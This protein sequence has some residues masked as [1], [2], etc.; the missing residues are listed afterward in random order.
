MGKPKD[1]FARLQDLREN[2]E[3]L[4]LRLNLG[5]CRLWGPGIQAEGQVTPVYPEGLARSHPGRE[6]P[7][8]PFGKGCGI[9]AL[10]VPID[11]PKGAPGRDPLVAPECLRKWGDAVEQTCLILERLRAYPEG[12]VRKDLLRYCLDACRVVHL[13]RSTELEEAGQSPAMLR[14]K[15]Q[16]VV[17][18]LLGT[19]ISEDAWE[20]VCLPI[21]LGGLGISDPFVL[22][23]AARLAALVNLGLN[24]AK[25]VGVPANV[26]AHP[27]PDLHATLGRL[28]AQLGPNMEPLARWVTEPNP[29]ASATSQH[30]TQKWWAEQVD[31]VR[32]QMVDGKGSVRDRVRRASQ[33]GPVATAWLGALP[34]RAAR[35]EIPDAEFRLL[36]RWW[37]GLPILPTG[38]TLPECPLCRES[39][40]PFGDHLVCCEQNGCA[41]RHNAFRN[42]FFAV[43][44]QHGIA[45]EK[46]PECLAGRRPADVLLLLWTRGQHV[47]VDFVCTHP[48][49]PAQYPLEGARG[50]KH[51]NRA[52]AS[53]LRE[54]SAP[55]Q[56]KGWGFSP[57]AVST[58]GGLGTSAKAVL[59]EVSKRATADLRG[60]PKTHALQAIR[61][62]LSVTLMREVAR[63]LTVKGRVQDAVCP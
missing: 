53:K 31:E 42:A 62:T 41:A 5:K 33:K 26:L 54:N 18:D 43:C 46:E 3:P 40:D 36:L 15:L 28:Q 34:S 57:F 37:L 1:V 35:T 23:P 13:L 14:A 50:A 16:E 7:V 51:C 21:R 39:V 20:Q 11:A 38:V 59:F 27:A 44:V 56:E 29:L 2:L 19:G 17:Q 12:Q 55:C 10:G 8:V 32:S 25:A 58:W 45:V 52:E 60:W 63:Q 6:V 61:E 9:T 47:A 4:G 48:A 22:Q 49:G 24:G 30:A